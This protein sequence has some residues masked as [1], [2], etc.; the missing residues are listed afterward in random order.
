MSFSINDVVIFVTTLRD[1]GQTSGITYTVN[2]KLK[3]IQML[4]DFGVDYIEVGW[5]GTNSVDTEL[6]QLL[7]LQKIKNTKITAF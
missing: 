2:D 4:S 1:G 3:L 6:F 5:P 7:E